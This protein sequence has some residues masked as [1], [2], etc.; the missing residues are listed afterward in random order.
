MYLDLVINIRT[1]A[2]VAS[3][4]FGQSRALPPLPRRDKVNFRIQFVQDRVGGGISSPVDVVDVTPLS[5]VMYLGAVGTPQADQFTWTK[6][7]VN[8][9][10]TGVLDLNTNLLEAAM[11][12][13]SPND[14]TRVLEIEVTEGSAVQTLQSEVKVVQRVF[15]PGADVPAAYTPPSAL[16]TNLALLL[17]DSADIDVQHAAGVFTFVLKDAGRPTYYNPASEAAMLALSAA[18]KGDIAVRS[19]TGKSY[20]LSAAPYSTLANWKEITATAAVSSVFGRTGAVVVTAGDYNAT[21]I[22][23]TPAGNISATTVQAALNELDAEKHTTQFLAYANQAAMLAGAAVVGDVAKLSDTLAVYGLSAL[24]ASTLANWKLLGYAMISGDSGMTAADK[25]RFDLCAC[26]LFNGLVRDMQIV[27][28]SVYVVGDFTTCGNVS[29]PYIAKIDLNGNV[30]PFFKLPGTGFDGPLSRVELASDGDL[31]VGF[32]SPD[33]AAGKR[34]LNGAAAKWVWKLNPLGSLDGAF[35][36][37]DPVKATFGTDS[38]IAFCCMSTYIVLLT[39]M[40]MVVLDLTG[41]EVFRADSNGD[42]DFHDVQSNPAMGLKLLLASRKLCKYHTTFNGAGETD[43]KGV[44]LISFAPTYGTDIFGEID[45]TWKLVGNGGTGGLASYNNIAV[46]KDGSNLAVG[47]TILGLGG[48]SYEWNGGSSTIFRGVIRLNIDGTPYAGFAV[49][50]T[51]GDTTSTPIP[52]AIDSLG[53]VYCGGNVS[54]VNGTSVTPYGLFRL[55][56]AGALDKEFGPFN[57]AVSIVKVLDDDRIIVG[58]AFTT[59][60]D[61]PVPIGRLLYLHADGSRWDECCEAESKYAPLPVLVATTANITLA[62]LQTIDGV[63]LALGDRVL[64]KD[65]TAGADNGIYI[66]SDGAWQRAADFDETREVFGGVRVFVNKGTANGNLAFT[67]TADD[68]ITLGTTALVFTAGLYDLGAGINGATAKT[69]PVDADKFPFWDSVSGLLRQCTWANIKSTLVTYFDPLYK[70]A[71]VTNTATAKTTPVDDDLVSIVDTEAANV[72]KKLSFTNL[73]AFLKTYFDTLY[74]AIYGAFVQL[75]GDTMIGRLILSS[76]PV[77]ALG[78]ATKQYADSEKSFP[79][80][81]T[82]RDTVQSWQGVASSADGVKLVA[83][84]SAGQIYT[85]TDSGATWTARDSIRNWTGVASSSD[86]VKLVAVVNAGQIYTSTDSGVNWTA[87]DSNR[88]WL[89]VAS[90]SDGVKLVAVVNAGQ[91]YTSTDSG[92]TWTARDSNRDWYAVASSEDGVKLVAVVFAGQIYTSTDSGVTWTARDS[93]RGWRGVASSGDGAKLV[94]ADADPGFIYTSTDSGVTWTAR[95]SSRVWWRVA[96]SD[97]GSRLAAV[98]SG[99]QIYTS[100]D[101]GVT[102]IA[103]DSSRGWY[104]VASSADGAK[105]VAV[106]NGGYI[107]TA[108]LV[109]NNTEK[110]TGAGTAYSLTGTSARVDFGTTDAEVTLPTAGTY[111]LLATVQ[112]AGDVLGASDEVRVKLYN[113]TDAAVVGVERS[114]TTAVASSFDPVDLMETITV[115]SSKTIQIYAHN[116]TSARG[117]IIAAKTEIKYVRLH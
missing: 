54:A 55:T 35:T 100:T 50:L 48:T 45:D 34:S 17:A 32:E 70:W 63:A 31:I 15:E 114:I 24:P 74:G 1:G 25:A 82:A 84:E 98:V 109:G 99:G 8:N 14:L 108:A 7:E 60:G 90:S 104:G 102:W 72:I 16:E 79:Q 93:N 4:V 5:L 11:S 110:A 62:A 26:G 49:N 53:R 76:D 36:C 59:Y 95:D 78:A 29:T 40:E 44:K 106:V 94:A 69:P 22:T 111:L 30:D 67:Q 46:A 61:A 83:F 37:P 71:T 96:S 64:V 97:D 80:N 68:P 38:V 113:S 19:D 58:G 47:C 101:S 23:N 116:A 56:A 28:E 85:S 65:Q 89:S 9:V 3:S 117:T 103:R 92:V 105:L 18:V 73:K 107:Y 88:V 52:F 43:P 41:A 33:A 77:T 20:F 42:T 91:I 81:W 51:I 21:Q 57:G 66:A 86:G 13:A 2:F 115:T 112:V 10:F 6:D 75:A 39:N 27:G 87:R 12:T